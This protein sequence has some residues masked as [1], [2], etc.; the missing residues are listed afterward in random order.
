MI[1]WV[2][3]ECR[4][5]GA[6]KRWMEFGDEDGWPELSLLGRLIVE[7]PGAGSGSFR[8]K[9]PVKDPPP[10]YVAINLALRHMAETHVMEL[11]L[12]VVGA[13][14]VWRDKAKVKAPILGIS[15]PHYWRQLHAAHAFIVGVYIQ[16]DDDVSRG[17]LCIRNIAVA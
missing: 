6:H 8:P 4:K 14:Y 11:P 15:L 10:S 5:W 16:R 12:R 1:P 9:V 17:A 2:D 7:G 3:H 13:H